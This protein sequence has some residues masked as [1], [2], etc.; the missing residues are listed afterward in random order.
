MS[1]VSKG[2][3][4]RDGE[5]GPG[6]HGRDWLAGQRSPINGD[7]AEEVCEQPSQDF[8]DTPHEELGREFEDEENLGR[9]YE[10]VPS[11]SVVSIYE[12]LAQSRA[13]ESASQAGDSTAPR[14]PQRRK[15][16][17]NDP[18]HN[19][20]LIGKPKPRALHLPQPRTTFTAQ[21]RLLI[22]DIWIRS[23]LPAGDFAPLVGV[24][25]HTLYTWRKRFEEFGPAGL[26]DHQRGAPAGSRLNEPTRRA[27]LM[28]KQGHPEWGVQRIH[29]V[30]LRS[31]GYSAC[32]SS[33]AKVLHEEGYVYEEKPTNPHGQEPKSFER[34]RP[35]QLWQ[36]DM[37]TFFLKRENRRVHLVAFMDDHSRFIVGFGLHATASG[38]P[39]REV[40]EAAIA[41]YGAPEEVLTDNGAQYRTWRGF[42]KFSELCERRGIRQIVSAP[43]HP[44]T[45]GKAERFWETLWG[46][47]L[48]TAIFQGMDDARRRIGLYIDYYNFQRTHQKIGGL[49]PAD[50]FFDAA[51]EVAQTLRAR[52]A[53]NALELA[54]NGVPRKTVY[55]TGK[56]GDVGIALHSE[57]D[58]VILTSENGLREVVN[59]AAP[60]KRAEPNTAQEL[61][62]PVSVQG[63][64]PEHPAVHA[65]P[66]SA[67]GTSPLDAG[68]N[69]LRGIMNP[70]NGSEA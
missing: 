45:V 27:I 29:D 1:G 30:L 3:E 35:N 10:S 43:R 46:E 5:H 69:E 66:P 18:R 53:Q 4:G 68:L 64:G 31:E 14:T 21:Q 40:L 12:E 60:G 34:A 32:A 51:P 8:A 33:I 39:I 59:L 44:Q 24:A 11:E 54:R 17:P 42:S 52:V 23:A 58:K 25:P 57:G 15:F 19:A 38:G 50:R 41:N 55:L 9:E 7:A 37:F 20:P 65:P 56:V 2:V 6:L 47:C 16:P 22:L 13:R 28:L 70:Q 62:V 63:V 67:P 61:P 26:S 36:T 48:G 49:V